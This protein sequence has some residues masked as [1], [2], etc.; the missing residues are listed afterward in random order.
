M[1]NVKIIFLL[2][3]I[4]FAFTGCQSSAAQPTKLDTS[5]LEKEKSVGLDVLTKSQRDGIPLNYTA[6][7]A[8][9]ALRALPFKMTV[10]QKLPFSS[11]GFTNI[12]IEDFKHNGKEIDV[13]FTAFS[14]DLRDSLT[15]S[16]NNH[17]AEYVGPNQPV[18]LNNRVKGLYGAQGIVFRKAGVN[19]SIALQDPGLNPSKMK[20]ELTD[21]ANQMIAD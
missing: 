9:T 1:K 14:K 7:S 13:K 3:I 2:L 16:A 4:M 10:P 19:Y 8:E 11:K 20:T 17:N 6:R 15:V 21:L 12:S 5:Q 18:Q